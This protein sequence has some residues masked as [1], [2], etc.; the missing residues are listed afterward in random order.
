MS[1]MDAEAKGVQDSTLVTELDIAENAK[2]T[3]LITE[4]DDA[5]SS[6]LLIES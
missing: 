6:D 1:A 4:P 3:I 5:L 2:S